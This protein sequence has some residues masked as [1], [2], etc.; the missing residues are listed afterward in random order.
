MSKRIWLIS[1]MFTLLFFIATSVFAEVKQGTSEL[2]FHLG[3]II[4]DDLMDTT[5]SGATVEL[6]NGFAWG[7]DYTYNFG[8]NWGIEGRYTW[9][10]S[11]ASG[12]PTS[13]D[14]DVHIFDINAVYHF[15]PESQTVFYATGG[16]GWA[17]GDL[18][19]NITGI[20]NGTDQSVSDAT[21]FTFNIGGG[22]KYYATENIVIRGD[23]R[24]RYI[25]ELV[26]KFEESLNTFEITAGIGY[27]F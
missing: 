3:G 4:G 24:Y 8:V 27:R 16:F 7:I 10:I 1:V 12:A 14:L 2:G 25:N 20:I 13:P 19:A 11:E 21:G 6:D 26:S 9:H 17:T 22:L 18:D 15:N 23:I 5:V